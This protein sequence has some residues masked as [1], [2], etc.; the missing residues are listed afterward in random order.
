MIIEQ[1]CSAADSWASRDGKLLYVT[2]GSNTNAAEN[3]VEAETGRA[4]ILNAIVHHGRLDPGIELISKPYSY[5]ALAAKIRTSLDLSQWCGLQ[6]HS[7]AGVSRFGE[8]Q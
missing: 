2:V 7:L 4:R 1:N 6:M 5:S 3:G 8:V